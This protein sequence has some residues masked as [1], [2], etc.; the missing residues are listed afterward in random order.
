MGTNGPWHTPSRSEGDSNMQH[1]KYNSTAT[2]SLHYTHD[3]V[4]NLRSSQRKRVWLRSWQLDQLRN[5][6]LR[7]HAGQGPQA[8]RHH[9]AN[10]LLLVGAVLE[11]MRQDLFCYGYVSL[12]F[13]CCVTVAQKKQTL[14]LKKWTSREMRQ[15]PACYVAFHFK[16]S[17][18]VSRKKKIG[19]KRETWNKKRDAIGPVSVCS[20]SY[21][22]QY[23]PSQKRK[24]ATRNPGWTLH[25]F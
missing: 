14:Q 8:L 5:Q 13:K 20:V 19:W 4:D 18:S 15:K 6:P 10:S 12:R 3:F 2:P 17:V 21:K 22:P 11:Q 1:T 9:V 16:C 24:R 23:R 7:V 25:K